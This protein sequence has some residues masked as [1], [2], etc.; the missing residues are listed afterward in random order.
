MFIVGCKSESDYQVLQTQHIRSGSARYTSST[1]AGDLSACR[2]EINAYQAYQSCLSSSQSGNSYFLNQPSTPPSESDT[3]KQQFGQFA[4]PSDTKSGYCKCS[5]GYVFGANN[6]CVSYEMYCSQTT[7]NSGS[8][9][10]T[11]TGKCVVCAS[12]EVRVENNC[13]NRTIN[14]Q[15]QH[16]ANTVYDSHK[17]ECACESSYRV[18]SNRCIA[19][20]IK[21]ISKNAKESAFQ[22]PCRNSLYSLTETEIS[23]C[24]DYQ[25]HSTDYTWEIYDPSIKTTEKPNSQ[26]VVQFTAQKPEESTTT[27]PKVDAVIPFAPHAESVKATIPLPVSDKSNIEAKKALIPKSTATVSSVNTSS[28]TEST[29]VNKTKPRAEPPRSKSQKFNLLSRIL[30]LFRR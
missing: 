28:S 3:C 10:N 27:L 9:L 29:T 12:D 14:C 25:L 22:G 13:V 8:W 7:G 4:I 30:N 24:I 20:E 19:K 2:S 23:E 6:Q 11:S 16:G 21:R 5:S 17:G 26:E 1:A 18:V 15:N